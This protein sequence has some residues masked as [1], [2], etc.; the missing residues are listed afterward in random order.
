MEPL[1]LAHKIVDTLEDKKGE[2]ILLLDL[3]ELAPISDYFVICSG[4]SDRTLK[5]LIDAVVEETRSDVK[6]KPRL[7]G[8][9]KEGWILADYGPVVVH[10]FSHA[11]RDYYQLEEL[12]SQG[13]V[14]LRIQ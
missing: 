7:E 12:W 5:A 8:K 14:V 13:K 4:A 9:P 10:I 6:V 11:Q 2:D 3:R 1:D